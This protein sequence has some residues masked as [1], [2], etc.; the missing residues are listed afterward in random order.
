MDGLIDYAAQESILHDH[1]PWLIQG[2]HWVAAGIDLAAIALVIL[3][4]LR[5]VLGVAAAEL[6][7]SGAAR[8]ERTNRRRVELGRYIL[9]S[10]ELFIVSDL[11]HVALSLAFADVLF[12]GALVVIRSIT[13]YFIEREI[14][15]LRRELSS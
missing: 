2:L 1:L 5:F 14:E 15:Q 6:G 3:G 4:A 13:S 10:L 11:I 8:V 9:A 7:D 12:L